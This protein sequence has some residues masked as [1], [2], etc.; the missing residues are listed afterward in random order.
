[1]QC[2]KD[3]TMKKIL[4]LLFLMLLSGTAVFAQQKFTFEEEKTMCPAVPEV[5]GVFASALSKITGMNF[6]LATTLES[7]VRKQMNEALAGDFKVNITPFG[8]K[9]M[10]EGKF[11]S[12]NAES[13][14]AAVE[15]L[16]LSNIKAQ[17]VCG[18]NHFV[19]KDGE[20]YTAENFLLGFRT[21]ITSQD[22]QKMVTTPEYIKKMNSMNVSVG[23]I[24]VF[25]LFS[26]KAEI[27]NNKLVISVMYIAP[28][29]MRSPKQAAIQMGLIAKDG[30][31]EF[32]DIETLSGHSSVS[33]DRL[34]PIL[35][36]LN[37]LAIKTNILN[38]SKSIIKL[39]DIY[40]INDKIIIKG[41]VIVPK[42]YYNN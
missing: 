8:G 7:Q 11:K 37:P 22:L 28:L 17:S 13:D 12:I 29:A 39:K 15:G 25:K 40:I 41:L 19:Y 20:V 18:Y 31:L 38:N 34:L 23:N 21:E 36:K 32:T 1:M 26:P 6:I 35:N 14:S 27:K 5:N 9:S 33:M 24:S 42:N 2:Y 4:V 3:F 10:L 16:Y 30:N